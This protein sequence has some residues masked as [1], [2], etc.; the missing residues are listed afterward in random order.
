LA[1]DAP[2]EAVAA[3]PLVST[4]EDEFDNSD[5]IFLDF[6]DEME[7]EE[8]FE[9]NAAELSTPET[10]NDEPIV[11]DFEELGDEEAS[12]S[13]ALADDEPF[14]VVARE[15]AADAEKTEAE[16]TAPSASKANQET[17]DK[18]SKSGESFEIRNQKSGWTPV[19]GNS[20][21]R[22]PKKVEK[23]AMNVEPRANARAKSDASSS[24]SGASDERAP[25][26][27]PSK[28]VTRHYTRAE[29]D[30]KVLGEAKT[31]ATFDAD[32]EE[33]ERVTPINSSDSPTFKKPS[34]D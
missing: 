19:V 24:W 2:A 1:N 27:L 8:D 10:A 3:A 33:L 18:A 5:L 22:A 15:N 30:E 4:E 34:K 7:F 32:W 28:F 26:A 21:P 20:E 25:S 14:V 12:V 6:P 9:E 13:N 16:F 31:L 23:V 29:V 17:V 11:I